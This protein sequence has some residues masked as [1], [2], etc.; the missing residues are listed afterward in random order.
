MPYGEPEAGDPF[1]IVGVGLPG[2]AESESDMAY[3]FA[4]EFA[5][6]GYSEQTLMALFINPHYRA[7]HGSY[8]ALGK[9]KILEIIKE[10][11]GVWGR[12]RYVDREAAE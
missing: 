2:S 3:T 5:R 4:E 1:E 10:C 11:V 9:E 12:V 8:L 7:A 6:L